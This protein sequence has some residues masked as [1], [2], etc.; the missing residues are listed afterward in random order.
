MIE[1]KV[2]PIAGH[3]DIQSFN[4]Q[5]LNPKVRDQIQELTI[6]IKNRLRRCAQDI[7]VIGYNLC[8]IKQKLKH[9]EFRIW[10]KTE[11][12]WSVSAANKFMH[13]SQRFHLDDLEE[14][15]ISPSALYMLAAPSTPQEVRTQ[16]LNKAKEGQTITF[17]FAKQLLKQ[18]QN[19]QSEEKVNNEPKNC[20]TVE[21]FPQQTSNQLLCERSTLLDFVEVGE[22]QLN[23]SVP[24]Y[25]S[26]DFNDSLEQEWQRMLRAEQ[27]LSLVIC[28]IDIENSTHL[29]S[30]MSELIQQ[31]SAG[32]AYSLKRT[33]D[34]VGEYNKNQF[35]AVLPNTNLEGSQSV[36]DRF[37]EWFT[38]WQKKLNQYD[39]FKTLKISLGI[40]SMVPKSGVSVHSLIETALL[41]KQLMD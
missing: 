2:F 16:A 33:G 3:S 19:E 5:Q 13:V 35:I 22:S 1:D 7:Y 14:V 29:Q 27:Y 30:L 38:P 26:C 40:A 8:Q 32:L 41:N 12:D 17:S 37:V 20:V 39:S 23:L 28:A 34:F 11:F 6:D 4:Y 9:G 18:N 21:V 31:V 25:K 24:I 36:V 10:L 15:E